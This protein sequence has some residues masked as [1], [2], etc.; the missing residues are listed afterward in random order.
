MLGL[1]AKLTSLKT[2]FKKLFLEKFKLTLGSE[3]VVNGGFDDTSAWTTNGDVTINNGLAT[4]DGTSQTSYIVQDVLTEGKTYVLTF[5][6][7]SDNGAGQ[8]WVTDNAGGGGIILN[9]TGNGSKSV[10]F[11]HSNSSG[12]LFFYARNGG[13][14]VLD[15]VS[16]K[17]A[18][19]QAPVAAF[20]LRKLGDVSPY[21]ARIRRSS[22]NTEAQVMFDASDRVSE[23]SVVRNTSQNILLYSEDFSQS[24]YSKINSGIQDASQIV[25]PFGGNNAVRL[26]AD[27]T[28]GQ[29]RLDISTTVGTGSHTFSVYAKAADYGSIWLRRQ[30]S[31]S[32]FNLENGTVLS[33]GGNNNPTITDVG[34]GWYRVSITNTGSANDTFRINFAPTDTPTSDYAG[35]NTSGIYIFGAQL[36][37]TVTYETINADIAVNG[38]FEAD[39]TWNDFGSPVTQNQSTEQV[40]GGTYSR[41]V[42]SSANT[43]G[44]QSQTHFSLT[45]GRTYKVSFWA[46]AVDGGSDA[47]VKSGLGNTDQG[48]FTNRPV[49]QGQWTNITYDAV[50]TSTV[51]AGS[52]I[53]FLTNGDTTTFYVDD[54][55]IEETSPIPSEYISTPVVS[56]DGLTFTES[57]LDTFVGGENLLSYS[58]NFGQW[59]LTAVSRTAD[60]S[61][62]DP[63]GGTGAYKL[64]E[65]AGSS[66]HFASETLTIGAGAHTFSC[67]MKAGERTTGSLM[68]TQAGNFGAVFNLSAGSVSSVTGTGN[69]A[70]IEAVGTDGWYRCAIHNTGSANIEDFVRIGT[71]NGAMGGYVG[72]ANKGIYIFGAQLNTDSLKTYQATT[73]TARDGNAAISVLY[74]QTGGEDAIQA[75]AAYQ[76]LLYNAGLLVRSG[77]SPAWL[78]P[79]DNPQ[80]NLIFQGVENK[81]H[82]D[83]FFVQDV[84]SDTQFMVPSSSSTSYY[85][86]AAHDGSTSTTPTLNYGAP[87]LEINGVNTGFTDRDDVYDAVLGRKLVYHRSASTT[88]WTNVQIGWWGTTDNGGWNIEGL[89][90]SEII[91][92]DSD[93][94]SNQAAIEADINDFHNIY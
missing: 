29:H 24:A 72:E 19:K 93:Q 8:R 3:L 27:T 70:S 83:A 71:Q 64:N 39:T 4:I 23:S 34:N 5:D 56:N 14:Y 9:M 81:A 67:Y 7:S 92:F 80:S 45:G 6:V 17:E 12:N 40:H 60:S 51:Q 15:N 58:E 54:L 88:N 22:D 48:V 85:G 63:F 20:S 66:F 94:H 11:T 32:V 55:T 61:V 62:T 82:I 30:G 10:T 37:E 65:T 18:I 89:K 46:Y 31:S 77:T 52:Y 87:A 36:E 86:F 74:N 41:K 33:D 73:G 44:I 49:T 53:S 91:W 57:T 38:D 25:D 90:F 28:N 35:T 1:G 79:V 13:S 42:V 2:L 43:K 59:D 26:A 68:L 21:A 78:Y 16:V 84:N 69:T 75:T 47:G 50:A 76:P